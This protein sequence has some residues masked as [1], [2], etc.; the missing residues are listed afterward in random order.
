MKLESYNVNT[1]DGKITVDKRI[2]NV[3]VQ[4]RPILPIRILIKPSSNVPNHY[5]NNST[6]LLF[7]GSGDYIAEVTTYGRGRKYNVVGYIVRI[8]FVKT[9]K[10]DQTIHLTTMP[11]AIGERFLITIDRENFPQKE[12]TAKQNPQIYAFDLSPVEEEPDIVDMQPLP[13]KDNGQKPLSLQEVIPGKDNTFFFVFN[14]NLI[15]KYVVKR[16]IK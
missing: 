8:I 2:G 12:W 5:M 4:P 9:A 11:V 15:A 1:D 3:F 16:R 6:Y 10:V 14:R 13:T 7:S